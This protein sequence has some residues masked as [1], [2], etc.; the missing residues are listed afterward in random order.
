[1]NAAQLNRRETA[2]YRESMDLEDRNTLVDGLL[3]S[4]H[5]G[6]HCRYN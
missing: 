6:H 2:N 1:M 4:S 3:P 5:F